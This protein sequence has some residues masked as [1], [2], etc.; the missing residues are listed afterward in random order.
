MTAANATDAA[1][2]A[3]TIMAELGPVTDAAIVGYALGEKFEEDTTFYGSGE[4]E[5]L[6]SI[7]AR[8]DANEQKF[9]TV[10]IPAPADGI[11]IA[12]SGPDYNVVDPADADLVAYLN[13]F[14]TEATLSDGES[15]LS[16]GTAG[17]VT[18]RR[19]HRGSRK[20]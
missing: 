19:I 16:P 17:N 20:G 12:A 15:L 11:F 1:T 18:G 2:D 7:S 9:A 3:A 5:N 6:A 8:V 10:K 13:L 4:I 14:T